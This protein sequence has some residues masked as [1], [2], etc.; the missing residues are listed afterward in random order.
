M[1][2]LGKRGCPDNLAT[3]ANSSTTT[4]STMY[5]GT[6]I[7]AAISEAKIPPRFE[8]CCPCFPTF[9][10]SN[11]SGVVAYVPPGIGF[12]KPPRPTTTSISFKSTFF[13]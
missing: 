9:K 6:L 11:N 4:G 12:N 10:S 7:S 1:E 2:V 13:L 5:E 8:A 3:S